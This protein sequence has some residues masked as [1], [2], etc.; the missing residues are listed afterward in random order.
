MFDR[1]YLLILD[2]TFAVYGR[3][4]IME[5][6]A[7]K[8]LSLSSST[9]ELSLKLS[10][11]SCLSLSNFSI[12]S[13]RY[14]ISLFWESI[15]CWSSPGEGPVYISCYYW[16]SR[17]S[18]TRDEYIRACVLPWESRTSVCPRALLSNCVPSSEELSP[19]SR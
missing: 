16:K 8:S 14:F 4:P 13:F 1:Y 9:L 18:S 3:S 7:S 6:C 15:T 5:D 12:F 10:I 2:S 17:G 19:S 11:M